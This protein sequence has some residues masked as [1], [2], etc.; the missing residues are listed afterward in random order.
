MKT[1]IHQNAF[2]EEIKKSRFICL[3]K[4]V[5]SKTE[6]MDFFDEFSDAS[7]NHNCWAYRVGNDYR[8]YDDGE[9]SGTAGKPIFSAIEHPNL[10]NV[11][12][13]V[14]RW[15][16][17]TKLGTGGLCRAY[18]GVAAKCLNASEK[19][20]I[21][22]TI[23]VQFTF[24]YEMTKQIY[25][26]LNENKLPKLTE[27]FRQNGI[28]LHTEVNEELFDALNMKLKNLSAG[29]ILFTK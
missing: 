24:P 2:Q 12:V 18:G 11:A 23:N 6:A 21:I 19:I 5:I 26:F 9:P 8:F 25:H 4:P 3:A 13:L 7:A 10:T 27:E 22:K 17:G 29:K 20:D 14:I 15:F 1:I 28:E 16:G